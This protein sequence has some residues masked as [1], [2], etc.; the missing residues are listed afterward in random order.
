MKRVMIVG[1]SGSGKSTMAVEL[2]KITGLPVQHLDLIHWKPRWIER[3]K[4]EK[5]SLIHNIESQDE[6]IIEGN[7]SA[8]FPNR[9]ARADVLIWLDLPLGLRVVRILKRHYQFRGKTRPDMPDNC[10]ERLERN[11]IKWVLFKAN[12]TR[13][14]IAQAIVDAPHLDARHIRTAR[15]A[16]TFLEWCRQDA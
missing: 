10:P 6:W 13:S 4:T 3:E 7:Y 14:E 15:G 16:D 11:Y 5:S 1:C 12:N 2:G 9:T 8:T